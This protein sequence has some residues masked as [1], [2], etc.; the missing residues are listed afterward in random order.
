MIRFS[1][2]STSMLCCHQAIEIALTIITSTLTLTRL[3]ITLRSLPV[4]SAHLLHAETNGD[5]PLLLITQ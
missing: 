4:E 2:S 3:L 5:R 1:I